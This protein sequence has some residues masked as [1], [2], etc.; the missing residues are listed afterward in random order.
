MLKSKVLRG[1]L[2]MFLFGTFGL[3]SCSQ[4]ASISSSGN[5]TEQTGSVEITLPDLSK[6]A[7]SKS[8]ALLDTN[9]LNLIIT[10]ANMDTIKYSWQ[11]FDLRG[12]KVRING[13]PAGVNR[14]F[15]GYLTEKSNIVTHTGKVAA[16]IE[17]GRVAQLTLK[18]SA[19][20][21]VDL[22]I[23]IEGYPSSCS[24]N[25]SIFFNS[26]VKFSGYYGMVDG[27]ISFMNS[28]YYV[29]GRMQFTDTILKTFTFEKLYTKKD[30]AGVKYFEIVGYCK[31]DGITAR[32]ELLIR[33]DTVL[34]GYIYNEETNVLLYKFYSVECTQPPL[35]TIVLSGQLNAYFYQSG[36]QDTGAVKFYMIVTSNGRASVHMSLYSSDTI[37]DLSL[38]G[39]GKFDP[40]GLYGDISV[41]SADTSGCNYI[42]G[43]SFNK[44]E[45]YIYCKGSLDRKGTS[46]SSGQ[47]A[48][49]Y[50]NL[51]Y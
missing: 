32:Y 21:S 50:G 34:N 4:N 5:P 14:Y 42:L 30:S 37:L 48:T 51:K 44:S 41:S 18:L 49:I 13:I 26:C 35:D 47:V 15:A 11:K 40:K 1:G 29:S 33:G 16:T 3:F 28:D 43:M 24:D 7:L 36:I 46:C 45:D 22:C 8:D 2:V 25:D 10:G 39:T 27:T 23:E 12:Q 6:G 38:Q 20:G 17:A 31:E 19:T 9:S